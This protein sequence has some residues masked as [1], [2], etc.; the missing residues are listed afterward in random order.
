M[1]KSSLQENSTIEENSTGNCIQG[2]HISLTLIIHLN[3]IKCMPCTKC[4]DFQSIH[5]MARQFTSFYW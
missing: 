5:P 2:L 4:C 1:M 3:L